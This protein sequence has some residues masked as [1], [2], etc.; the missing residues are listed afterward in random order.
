MRLLKLLVGLP[1]LLAAQQS[2]ACS[3]LGV[4]GAA[5]SADLI[6]SGKLAQDDQALEDQLITKHVIKGAKGEQFQIVWPMLFGD[7]CD[8]F[9]PLHRDKGVFFLEKRPDGKY[10]V[11]WT[12][13]RW[14]KRWKKWLK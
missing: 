7:E 5:I 3:G 4:R 9:G 10:Q 11:I 1:L 14:S 6:V 13:K 2:F 12:E 8:A